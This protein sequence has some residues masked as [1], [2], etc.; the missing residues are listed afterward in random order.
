MKTLT[1]FNK[2]IENSF[3]KVVTLEDLQKSY[4]KSLDELYPSI[5]SY[6]NKDAIEHYRLLSL[7]EPTMEC[8]TSSDLMTRWH[9]VTSVNDHPLYKYAYRNLDYDSWVDNIYKPHMSCVL[10]SKDKHVA[11]LI[12]G[13]CK[14]V[15]ICLSP[16]SN[17]YASTAKLH[18]QAF[19]KR[20]A[21]INC[22]QLESAKYYF[23]IN[24]KNG[25]RM[26]CHMYAKMK[27]G[28]SKKNLRSYFK[29]RF[30]YMIITAIPGQSALEHKP[31]I[32]YGWEEYLTGLASDV[33]K[34]A[35]KSLDFL[36]REENN[37]PHVITL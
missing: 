27:K 1:D 29:S 16:T 24:T 20:V 21:G 25:K 19:M 6:R 36:W 18:C 8:L 17:F 10:T 34:Q 37:I 5:H 35:N 26:H 3:K 11:G 9:H 31:D 33:E 30:P 7:R 28:G 32:T 13:H 2:R 23:E 22:R 12:K 14:G 15:Q 4:Q